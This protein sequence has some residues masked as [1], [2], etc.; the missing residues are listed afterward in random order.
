MDSLLEEIHMQDPFTKYWSDE[1]NDEED[2]RRTGKGTKPKHNNKS[3]IG[4]LIVFLVIFIITLITVF[5]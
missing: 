4:P 3:F 2:L 1:Y 5:L